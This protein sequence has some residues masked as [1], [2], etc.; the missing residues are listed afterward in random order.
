MGAGTD[1]NGITQ[2]FAVAGRDWVMMDV[3][4]ACRVQRGLATISASLDRPIK[5]DKMSAEQK[6]AGDGLHHHRELAD[7]LAAATR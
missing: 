4:E 2:A 5:K 6:G 7:A 1:G 3:G